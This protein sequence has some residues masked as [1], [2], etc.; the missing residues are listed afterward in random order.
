MTIIASH[1]HQTRNWFPL[2]ALR[3]HSKR[4]TR[5]PPP[6][7]AP[8][9]CHAIPIDDAAIFLKRQRGDL[10]FVLQSKFGNAEPQLGPLSRLRKVSRTLAQRPP[11]VLNAFLHLAAPPPLLSA[12]EL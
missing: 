9:Q 4:L 8:V 1:R 10:L 3:P 6:V 12:A 7:A 2:D 5:I 11:R